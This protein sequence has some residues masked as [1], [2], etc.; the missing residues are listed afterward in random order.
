METT[1]RVLISDNSENARAALRAL[2]S[3]WGEIEIVG[4]AADGQEAIDLVATEQPD[5]VL[6][7]V[8]M[9]VLDGLEATRQIKS[10]WPDVGVIVVTMYAAYRARALAAGADRFVSKAAL[11]EEWVP[12]LRAV[13]GDGTP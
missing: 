3:T 2:L 12:W 8:H 13:T 5:V 7:D 1:I 9:P 4:E 11:P 6:L 10:R